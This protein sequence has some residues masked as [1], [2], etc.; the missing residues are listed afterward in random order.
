MFAYELSRASQTKLDGIDAERVKCEERA[1]VAEAEAENLRKQCVEWEA[2]KVKREHMEEQ[3][4]REIA[5]LEEKSAHLKDA[6]AA[7]GRERGTL[8]ESL[9]RTEETIKDMTKRNKDMDTELGGLRESIRSQQTQY[10]EVV[11]ALNALEAKNKTLTE[12]LEVSEEEEYG[13]TKEHLDKLI[14]DVR[15]KTK[16]LAEAKRQRDELA[17]TVLISSRE[18]ERNANERVELIRM[19]EELRNQLQE[20]LIGET[21]LRSENEKLTVEHNKNESLK[22]RYDN[23]RNK[24]LAAQKELK[25]LQQVEE[26]LRNDLKNARSTQFLAR[27][28]EL[29]SMRRKVQK[30]NRELR[31]SKEALMHQEA[32]LQ[33]LE[34]TQRMLEAMKRTKKEFAMTE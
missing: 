1:F 10:K 24:L 8:Q 25:R 15:V 4:K 27:D 17:E 2:Y 6:L 30:Q 28:E 29:Q 12:T 32:Q 19:Q 14:E 34:S 5:S 16:Q 11:G 9:S 31:N 26:E 7:A 20:H 23:T 22:R 21:E 33:N 18:R 3:L 13:R